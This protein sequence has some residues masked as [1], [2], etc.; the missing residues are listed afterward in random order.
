M[1]V[2]IS[3]ANGFLGSHLT[4]HFLLQ[5]YVVI[6]VVRSTSNLYRI[7]DLIVHPNL[8]LVN[9]DTDDLA[10]AFEVGSEKKVIAVIHAATEYGRQPGQVES[11]VAA[12]I[13]LPL[14]LLQL[15]RRNRVPLFINTDSYF[16]KPSI[17]YRHLKDYS[18][19]KRILLEWLRDLND[20]AVVNMRLEHLYGPDDSAEKFVPNVILSV[21][22]R[23]DPFFNMTHGHQRR[24]FVHVDDVVRAFESVVRRCQESGGRRGGFEDFEIGTGKANEIRDVAD[25]V[26]EFSQSRTEIRFG[27]IPYRGD[28][29]MESFANETFAQIFEWFP[30]VDLRR[31]ITD[32]LRR[33]SLDAS[34]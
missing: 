28:E 6:G 9:A 17:T 33:G 23:Q 19:S 4:R 10:L 22:L 21:A 7:S 5:G 20:I 8:R 12:N 27:A 15:A 24:D 34:S 25:M 14:T 31:G 26:R 16:N 3:G 13:T 11:V 32:L 18:T 29:I 2:V 30:E 1:K